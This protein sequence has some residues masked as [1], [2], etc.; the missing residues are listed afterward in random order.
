[1]RSAQEKRGRKE[2]REKGRRGDGRGDGKGEIGDKIARETKTEGRGRKGRR[3]TR[4]RNKREAH[5]RD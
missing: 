5:G 2:K 1:V 3:S 4:G